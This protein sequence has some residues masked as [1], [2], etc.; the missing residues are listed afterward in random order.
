MR[1]AVSDGLLKKGANTQKR[2]VE[3]DARFDVKDGRRWVDDKVR[4]DRRLVD[5]V[6]DALQWA[7]RGLLDRRGDLVLQS[8]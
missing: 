5:V 8:L 6:E 3:L 7:I 1:V 4:L 2:L